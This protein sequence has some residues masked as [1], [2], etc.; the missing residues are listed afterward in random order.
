MT[1]ERIVYT[2]PDGGVSVVIPTGEVDIDTLMRK[3]VP[4]DATG[5]RKCTTADLPDR[6]F[7]EAWDDSNP[8]NFVGVNLVKAKEIAHGKRR[9]KRAEEFAP[10][11]EVIAK[12]I[13]GK[14][15]NAAETARQAIR[16]AD[17]ITQANID[18]AKDEAG[19][20]KEMKAKGLL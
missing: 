15:A 14:D 6:V 9:A 8:E 13:P 2:R 16:D 5:V 19:L 3:V 20:R 18:K 7:R 12:Q 11:D 1:N 10:H 17:A 4:A